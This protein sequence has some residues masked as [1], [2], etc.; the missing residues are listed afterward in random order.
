MGWDYVELVF[1]GDPANVTPADFAVTELGGDGSAPSVTAVE[2]LCGD[3]VGVELSG[4]L[5]P[6]TWTTIT[7]SASGS[8]TR[9]GYLPADA[10]GDGDANANDIV[11]HVDYMNAGQRERGSYAVVA[12]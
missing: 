2:H 3:L 1:N 7:H 4:P 8:S 12:V 11:E 5:E 6:V 9:L 10:G